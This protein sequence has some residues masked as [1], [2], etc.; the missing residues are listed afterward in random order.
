LPLIPAAA[1]S[2]FS[3]SMVPSNLMGIANLLF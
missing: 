1:M 2:A 3:S